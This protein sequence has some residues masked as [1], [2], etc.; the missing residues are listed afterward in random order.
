MDLSRNT[1][2]SPQDWRKK[3]SSLE[4][5]VAYI[6]ENGLYFDMVFKVGIHPNQTQIKA[7]KIVVISRSEVF[8][9]KL[10]KYLNPNSQY[11][12]LVINIPDACPQSFQAF[13][14][15]SVPLTQCIQ[16]IKAPSN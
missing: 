5:S 6:F 1:A 2:A 9:S 4:K 15:V 12:T 8:A 16:H 13:L 7:H 3:N 14:T 11:E 10:Q